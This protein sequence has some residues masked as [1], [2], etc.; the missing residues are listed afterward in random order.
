MPPK[1]QLRKQG[2][3]PSECKAGAMQRKGVQDA[4]E[5]W[6]CAECGKQEDQGEAPKDGEAHWCNDCYWAWKQG[7]W[8][9]EGAGG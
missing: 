3:A 5:V 9:A 8:K 7:S 2:K 4:V 6:Y 1:Q